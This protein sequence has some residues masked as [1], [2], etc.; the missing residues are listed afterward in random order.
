MGV[1]QPPTPD[2]VAAQ[3]ASLRPGF[4]AI[5]SKKVVQA[6]VA[7]AMLTL[8]VIAIVSFVTG[9]PQELADSHLAAAW[10]DHFGQGDRL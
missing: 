7:V 5:N 4:K 10:P 9:A 6:V 3:P 1:S 8:A 2:V